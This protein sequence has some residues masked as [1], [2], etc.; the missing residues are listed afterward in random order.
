MIN[1]LKLLPFTIYL[2]I[3]T[4]YIY[5]VYTIYTIYFT[6][7]FSYFHSFFLFL[8]NWTWY[9]QNVL[10]SSC[11][12]AR[13]FLTFVCRVFTVK[14]QT[15]IRTDRY[16]SWQ[17]SGLI[18]FL[19]CCRCSSFLSFICLNWALIKT[20][21]KLDT[22]LSCV[23]IHSEL[24]S[25]VKRAQSVVNDSLF[26][27]IRCAE[28]GLIPAFSQTGS[29]YSVIVCWVGCCPLISQAAKKKKNT[30]E[31]WMKLQTV[32][33]CF[34]VTEVQVCEKYAECWVFFLSFYHF[35]DF[36]V[37]REQWHYNSLTHVSIRKRCHISICC[38]Q[39]L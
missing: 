23:L 11:W 2:Y 24:V 33:A 5:S 4:L 16:E 8:T 25:L 29:Q 1:L 39:F 14:S 27:V 30:S 13:L 38:Y 7:Y 26:C 6:V 15:H 3:V 21:T 28:L 35:K 22:D 9:I 36:F 32:F 12:D 31:S 17:L 34:F 20:N 37:A 19:L 10:I 18:I